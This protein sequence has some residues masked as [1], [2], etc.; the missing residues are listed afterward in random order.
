MI[1]NI[2][3]CT[4]TYIYWGIPPLKK[5]E[6]EREKERERERE[7]GASC[8]HLCSL[9]IENFADD[10]YLINANKFPADEIT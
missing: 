5:R 9:S 4:Y 10:M 2:K 1:E 7:C 3:T 8:R 6:R